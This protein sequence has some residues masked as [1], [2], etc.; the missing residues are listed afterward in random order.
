MPQA[1]LGLYLHLP[2]C[3]SRCRYCH[4]N[5]VVFDAPLEA[6]YAAA[7][8]GEV[9]LGAGAPE[10]ARAN[11]VY[12]GGG[13]PSLLPA[14]RIAALLDACRGRFRLSDTCE[15]SLE[16]NP[17]TLSAEKAALW[18][19]WGVNRV[20]LGAQSFSDRELGAAGRAHT[21]SMTLEALALL[22]AS[23][24]D[25]LSLDLMLGL[26]H[27]TPRS[28]RRTLEAAASSGVAHL[29]LYMLDLDE[30]CPLGAMVREGTVTLPDGDET[31][32]LYA[33]S[34]EYLAG[35]GFEQ[36]EISNF[37]RPG[38]RSRHNL[39][40]WRREPVL[41]FGAGACSFDG[42]RRWTNESGVE[43]YCR[44]IES[45]D[46]P[47][48][49][50]ETIEGERALSETLFLSLRL[51]EGL[52]LARLAATRGVPLPEA[53]AAAIDEFCARGWIERQGSRVRLTV[54]GMLLSNEIFSEFL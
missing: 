6:R 41:A 28:W 53:Y 38:F 30:E 8:L 29:S 36:Y 45:G 34:V 32:D 47:E 24:F 26:P 4:F 2:F 46:P 51:T 10:G 43:E 39:K 35:C 7:L 44:R 12:F 22:R 52:D 21:A 16:A 1:E 33:E 3:L 42:R 14:E 37:S 27:Q 48:V 23:G 17:G 18:R 15:I 11:S 9:K 49:S 20:S 5:S 50:G 40:Y 25:N 19:S 13:T 54:P 31:A